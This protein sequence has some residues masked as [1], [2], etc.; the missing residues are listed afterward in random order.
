M[1][2]IIIIGY[3]GHAKVIQ[4][5]INARGVSSVI[6][7]IDIKDHKADI[8]YLGSDDNIEFI[9][10]R[11]PNAQYIIGIGDIPLRRKIIRYYEA[12][13]IRF[14]KVIHPS[15]VISPSVEIGNGTVVFPRAVVNA[16]SIIGAHCILNTGSIVE[17]DNMLGENVHM[18][19]GTTTGGQVKIGTDTLVGIGSSVKN[20]VSIGKASI[21]G[22]GTVVVKDVPGYVV[23][24]GVPAKLR[25][26]TKSNM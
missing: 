23:V 25:K 16:S 24:Y 22:C 1:D 10:N 4:D 12:Y 6:G 11:Y 19:P 21:V 17:H 20:N 2:Q 26:M 13:N 18:G 15:A 3:G 5:C 14:A 8:S 7:Y 9:V